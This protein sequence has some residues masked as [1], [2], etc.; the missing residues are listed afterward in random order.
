MHLA[1]QVK[2]MFSCSGI[3]AKIFVYVVRMQ[4]HNSLFYLYLIYAVMLH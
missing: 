2:N 4:N 1:P 3:V